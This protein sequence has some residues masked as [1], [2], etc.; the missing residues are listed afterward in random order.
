MHTLKAPRMPA[1]HRR[2]RQGRIQ[3]FEQFGRDFPRI[4]GVQPIAETPV[5]C[6]VCGI[7]TERGIH[8]NKSGNEIGPPAAKRAAI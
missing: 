7:K 2:I 4:F 8:E 3:R 1:N 5:A 6:F